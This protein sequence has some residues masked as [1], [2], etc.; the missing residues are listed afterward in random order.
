MSGVLVHF[1]RWNL[2]LAKAETQTRP[3]E[4]DCLVEHSAGR[5]VLAEIGVWHG[6]TTACLRAVMASDGVLY[7]IDPY[8]VGRLGFSM[9]RRIARAEVRRVPN[10]RVEW[11]RATGA[12]AARTLAQS[13]IGKLEFAF[14]DGDHSYEGLKKDWEEWAGLI[15]PGGVVG[16]HDSRPTPNRPIHDAGSVRYTREVIH[17]DPR[18]EVVDEVESLTV[19]RRV[20]AP[21]NGTE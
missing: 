2:G 9:Q 4:R 13:V 5:R 17:S 3:A 1:L 14:I 10:G 21:A 6:V 15:A 8:P 11:I 16:L 19:L 12:E 20:L 18:F 7:A